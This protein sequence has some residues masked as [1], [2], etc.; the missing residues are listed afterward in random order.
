[1]SYQATGINPE[2]REIVDNDGLRIKLTDK[3]IEALYLA[4]LKDRVEGKAS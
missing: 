4:V 2:R 1:M 3:Q